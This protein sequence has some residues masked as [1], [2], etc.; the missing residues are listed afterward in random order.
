LLGPSRQAPDPRELTLSKRGQTPFLLVAEAF[1]REHA[2]GPP[3]G[4]DGRDCADQEGDRNGDEEDGGV[5]HH[6]EVVD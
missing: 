2:G 1:Y 4:G 5:D 6:W 3:R